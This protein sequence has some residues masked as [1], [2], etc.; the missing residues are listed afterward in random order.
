MVSM[1]H[2]RV[3]IRRPDAQTGIYQKIVSQNLSLWYRGLVKNYR[4]KPKPF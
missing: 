4:L 2:G 1:G 3:I